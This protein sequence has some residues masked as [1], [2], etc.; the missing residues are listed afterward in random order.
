MFYRGAN[1]VTDTNRKPIGRKYSFEAK[2]GQA[3]PVK[4][5]TQNKMNE[6]S[7]SLVD[8]LQE[9]LKEQIAI[10][11]GKNPELEGSCGAL[12]GGLF[13]MLQNPIEFIQAVI[14]NLEATTAITLV[15]YLYAC[16]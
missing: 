7:E 14:T 8:N 13:Y 10:I 15:L 4:L 9:K 2:T 11:C 1:Q 16:P 5:T 12:F 3:L 6:A